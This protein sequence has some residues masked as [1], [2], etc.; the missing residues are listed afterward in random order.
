MRNVDAL[1][2]AVSDRG[3]S[4]DGGCFE[5]RWAQRVM[6]LEIA[7][8][9]EQCFER[10]DHLAELSV[11]D[12]GQTGRAGLGEDRRKLLRPTLDHRVAVSQESFD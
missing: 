1:S 10:G 3:D 12:E 5:F 8:G 4:C 9:P 2:Q 7:R 11:H 6:S